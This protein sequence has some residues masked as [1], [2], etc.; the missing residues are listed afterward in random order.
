NL[1]GAIDSLRI[2]VEYLAEMFTAGDTQIVTGVLQKLAAMRG[3]M[4]D[5]SLGRD[6]DEEIA[7]AVGMTGDAMEQ[8]Y[9]LL[10]IAKYDDR[11]VIPHAHYEQAHNREEMGCSVNFDGDPAY[12]EGPC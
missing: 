9:R 4:R 3:Y 7:E 12:E 11:Y 10:A 6:G 5:V 2:P 8:M 1:F